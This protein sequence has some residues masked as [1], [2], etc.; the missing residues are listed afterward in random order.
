M[1]L[2]GSSFTVFIRSLLDY[3]ICVFFNLNVESLKKFILL[4]V[5]YMYI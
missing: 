4:D 3:N 1:I 2:S 5:I